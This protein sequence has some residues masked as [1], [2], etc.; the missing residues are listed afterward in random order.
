MKGRVMWFC[1][2]WIFVSLFLV[3]CAFTQPGAASVAE[4][5]IRNWAE[6]RGWD[7]TEMEVVRDD[8]F[9]GSEISPAERAN[10]IT[11]REHFTVRFALRRSSNKDWQD[12][13]IEFFSVKENGNW[14]LFVRDDM[15][16]L[17]LDCVEN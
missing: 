11:A 13:G 3:C 5:C 10:G 8:F 9:P 15:S 17:G 4:K 7:V 1:G 2:V 14:K 12:W 6:E 16:Y